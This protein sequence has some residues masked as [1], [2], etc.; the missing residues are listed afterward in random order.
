M[1]RSYLILHLESIHFSGFFPKRD[2]FDRVSPVVKTEREKKK[3]LLFYQRVSKKQI[4]NINRRKVDRG[5]IRVQLSRSLF[6]S[7]RTRADRFA[8]SSGNFTFRGYFLN[9]ARNST[10]LSIVNARTSSIYPNRVRSIHS[11]SDHS[12]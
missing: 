6:V 9:N 7:F 12:F 8:S 2:P 10:V 3:K 11:R 5:S 1:V 4:A